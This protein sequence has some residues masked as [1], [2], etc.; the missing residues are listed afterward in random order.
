MQRLVDKAQYELQEK[1]RS[2]CT[3]LNTLAMVLLGA[4][5]HGG[6]AR[7]HGK[8][9]GA[10][11]AAVAAGAGGGAAAEGPAK[12]GAKG[13]AVDGEEEDDPGV[14]SRCPVGEAMAWQNRALVFVWGLY[15]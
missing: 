12:G 4:A 11:A 7:K 15:D 6:G 1:E 10:A 13:K 14:L 9:G 5:G 2:L 8:A 3:H